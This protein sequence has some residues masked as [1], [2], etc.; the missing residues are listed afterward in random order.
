MKKKQMAFLTVLI[1]FLSAIGPTAFGYTAWKGGTSGT[2][3]VRANWAGGFPT[4]DSTVRLDHTIQSN[5]YTVIIQ[6]DTIT[7]ILSI[8]D[9][10]DVPVR[11]RVDSTGSL[12]LNSLRMGSKEA[13]R[14]SSFTIDGG[15]VWGLNS[16]DPSVTNTSF[17]IGD[18]PGCTA[19]LN[20]LNNGWMSVMGSNGLSVANGR[21]STGRLIVTNGNVQIRESMILGRGPSSFGEL[22]LSGTSSFSITDA[23][24][25]AK[26]DSGNF[27][28][29]GIVQVAGGT[30]ECETLNIGANGNGSLTLNEGTVRARSGG[31]TLGQ[32]TSTAQLKIYGGTLETIGSFLHIGHLDSTGVLFMTNG[33]VNIDGIIALGSSSRSAGL[34]DVS[35]GTISGQQ[36]V[37]GAAA[38]STGTVHI[39]QGALYAGETIQVGPLGTGSLLLDGGTLISTNFLLGGG[40]AAECRL[41]G[42]ELVIIGATNNSI[43]ISNSVLHLEKT[44]IK[45]S[46]SN[47]TDWITNAV[48]TGAIAWSN[49]L[50]HGTYSTNGFDGYFTSEGSTLYWDNLENGSS[51]TQSVIWVEESP[52]NTW[53]DSYLLSGTDALWS[54]DP[55]HD[56]LDNLS[57]FGFG[58]NP[59]NGSSPEILPTFQIFAGLDLAEYVYRQR[60]DP[61]AYGLTY[62]LE[63]STNLLAQSWTTNGYSLIGVSPDIEGFRTITNQIPMTDTDAQF[64]RLQIQYDLD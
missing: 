8:Q 7:D 5:S 13:D 57:E 3:H 12:Q 32:T 59:T 55:D 30:L 11:V 24:H 29:T 26:L 25:I 53:A 47:V 41:T 21:E 28:P 38:S 35:G 23:L 18:N 14:E 62:I 51:F 9:Y 64:I 10:D 61:A 17:L 19:T 1:L 39:Q 34:L 63:L 16:S 44:L 6:T 54:A 49:G 2:W 33:N 15:S 4:N 31:I 43:Q 22:L 27:T 40:A 50:A 36:L 56:G 37:I 20:V 60:S 58:G 45:W 42:G 52:Y 48:S 46:N